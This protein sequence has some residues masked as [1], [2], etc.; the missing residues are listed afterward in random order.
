MSTAFHGSYA[1]GRTDVLPIE[2]TVGD[3]FGDMTTRP[4]EIEE[5]LYRHPRVQDVQVV[6]VPDQ[7]FGE[8]LCAWIIAKPGQQLTEDEVRAFCKGRIA[9]RNDHSR[10]VSMLLMVRGCSRLLHPYPDLRFA[11]ALEPQAEVEPVSRCEGAFEIDE[12]QMKPTVVA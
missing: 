3:F 1:R 11:R 4:R 9:H 10:S 6:G 12:L 5:F 7:R 2:Q 8:E